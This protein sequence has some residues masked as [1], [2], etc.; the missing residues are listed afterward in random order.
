MCVR[1]TT[2]NVLRA[3]GIETLDRLPHVF[4]LGF[5]TSAPDLTTTRVCRCIQRT[6]QC[7]TYR[8]LAIRV[9]LPFPRPKTFFPTRMAARTVYVHTCPAALF[10]AP[11]TKPPWLVSTALSVGKSSRP[12]RII[13][14]SREGR[15]AQS[16]R[17]GAQRKDTCFCR[18]HLA[19]ASRQWGARKSTRSTYIQR[20]RT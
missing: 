10:L 1:C 5:A 17:Q 3:L 14:G 12:P 7:T 2:L 11:R 18:P 13:P 4:C 6:T 20:I 16:V 19:S 8:T 9:C 15:N